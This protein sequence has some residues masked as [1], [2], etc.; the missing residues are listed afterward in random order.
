M[1][2]RVANRRTLNALLNRYFTDPRLNYD[3]AEA[4]GMM[5]LNK[6]QEEFASRIMPRVKRTLGVKD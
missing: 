5:Y 4:L 2:D 6:P 1:P 3:G